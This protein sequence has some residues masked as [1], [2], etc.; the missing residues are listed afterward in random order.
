MKKYITYLVLKIQYHTILKILHYIHHYQ[1]Y[2]RS[3][4][5]DRV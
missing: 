4:I 3:Y 5:S 1:H 2:V